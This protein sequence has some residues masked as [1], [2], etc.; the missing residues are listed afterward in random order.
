MANTRIFTVIGVMILLLLASC[1]SSD[2]FGGKMV[3]V[4][5]EPTE[6][7]PVDD[8]SA[9]EAA[10][11]E[12][13][14]TDEAPAPEIPDVASVTEIATY[15]VKDTC[16]ADT[17]GVVRTFDSEGRKKVFRPFCDGDSVVTFSCVDGIARPSSKNCPNGCWTSPTK[18]SAN[19]TQMS[20]QDAQLEDCRNIDCTSKIFRRS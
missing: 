4:E 12:S 9:E 11:G 16:R 7:V 14:K 10:N 1:R 8:R 17:L 18:V 19:A 2:T 6:G 5:P 13:A 20:L 15:D 3:G